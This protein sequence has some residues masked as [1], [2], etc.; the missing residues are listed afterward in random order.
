MLVIK[1]KVLIFEII[2]ETSI[3]EPGSAIKADDKYFECF[4]AQ[5]VYSVDL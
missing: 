4:S 3:D 2:V 5:N 1:E